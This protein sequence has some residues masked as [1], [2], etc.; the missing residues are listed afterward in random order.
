MSKRN[1]PG[2]K[3][4]QNST[5]KRVVS[6]K[7]SAARRRDLTKRLN[8][9]PKASESEKP[10]S[11]TAGE[12]PAKFQTAAVPVKKTAVKRAAPAK[13]SA[14]NKPLKKKNSFEVLNK[15]TDS[16]AKDPSASTPGPAA[17]PI[18]KETMK[19]SLKSPSARG[20][21]DT[22]PEPQPKEKVIKPAASSP[23]KSKVPLRKETM[24]VSLKA[25]SAGEPTPPPQEPVPVSKSSV[26]LR[27]ETMR[28]SLKA[29]GAGGPTT[30]PAQPVAPESPAAPEEVAYQPKVKKAV[31]V[32]KE[33]I[34]VSLKA[35]SAEEVDPMENWDILEPGKLAEAAKE[36]PN[37]K[38]APPGLQET[39]AA[40][41]DQIIEPEPEPEPQPEE[42]PLS[43][44]QALPLR[45]ETMRVSVKAPFAGMAAA[46]AAAAREPI[47]STQPTA[48]EPE[49]APAV[50]LEQSTAAV[51][52]V[53]PN[54]APPPPRQKVQQASSQLNTPLTP[55]PIKPKKDLGSI[56]MTWVCILLGIVAAVMMYLAFFAE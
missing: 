19:I 44:D 46:Q 14:V 49:P 7:D 4:R 2:K 26:P 20:P 27:K 28:V 6:R 9:A 39:P 34:R 48:P 15:S 45:K 31:P 3:N 35:P 32:R 53:S 10:A 40:S 52:I 16:P 5:G 11:S 41:L 33:T 24:R 17:A 47:L 12:P 30:P 42:A 8:E 23:T 18:G 51:G 55:Q 54:A 22:P 56:L 13:K 36:D 1:S 29:P 38:Y 43:L 25:P 50:V 37:Q 21:E